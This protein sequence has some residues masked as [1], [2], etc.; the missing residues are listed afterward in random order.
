MQCPLSVNSLS[1][2]NNIVSKIYEITVKE[3]L[4]LN[5]IIF[6]TKN[7]DIPVDSVFQLA[8]K[9]SLTQY[10]NVD[11]NTGTILLQKPLDRERLV[12]LRIC[13]QID[14]CTLVLILINEKNQK[15]YHIEIHIED[16]NDNDPQFTA[17]FL[18]L[19]IPENVPIGYR[20][21]LERAKDLDIGKNA[22]I[23][24][25]LIDETFGE[26]SSERRTFK[27]VDDQVLAIEV[28][29]SLDFESKSKYSLKLIANDNGSPPRSTELPISINI[30]DVN[31]NSPKCIRQK[32]SVSVSEN[33]PIYSVLAKV[34]ATDIDSGRN[35]EL[36]YQLLPIEPESKDMFDIDRDTGTIT[37]KVAMDYEKVRKYNLDVVVSD[38]G[39]V[40]LSTICAVEI[41]VTD[42]ND[43]DP[44]IEVNILPKYRDYLI[45]SSNLIEEVNN[46]YFVR[47]REDLPAKTVIGQV[48]LHDRDNTDRSSKMPISFSC[49][50]T[51]K[52]PF[53]LSGI[54]NFTYF[55]YSQELDREQ[56]E[57]YR[58]LL[59]VNDSG[60]PIRSSSVIFYLTVD[61]VNDN[62][63]V[64]NVT[65]SKRLSVRENSAIG[66]LISIINATDA[67][68]ADTNNSRIRFL[69]QSN[70]FR[71]DEITGH[72][73]S[74]VV[75]D[76]EQQSQYQIEI[77]AIDQNV[78]D[79][80]NASL[81]LIIDI[82]DEND[83]PPKF[84]FK[85]YNFSVN[86]NIKIGST[87]GRV[88]ATDD[89]MGS[90]AMLVYR[91]CNQTKPDFPFELLPD[92]I[93]RTSN[94]IDYEK[95][96]IYETEICVDD[97]GG[98]SATTKIQL[99]DSTKIMF[100]I[101][102]L[103]DN[104]PKIQLPTG[105]VMFL[106][107]DVTRNWNITALISDA[108]GLIDKITVT[109][110]HPSMVARHR[111]NDTYL[112]YFPFIVPTVGQYIVTV[113]AIDEM[114]CNV[115]CSF[116][117][118]VGDNSTEDVSS[119][120]ARAELDLIRFEM[121]KTKLIDK[122]QSHRRYDSS[123]VNRKESISSIT[124]IL[125]TLFVILIIL[126][127]LL[128]TIIS[129]K[130]KKIQWSTTTG[131]SFKSDSFDLDGD[132]AMSSKSNQEQ[133]HKQSTTSRSSNDLPANNKRQSSSDTMHVNIRR[134]HFPR[135][136]PILSGIS[137][138]FG[139]KFMFKSISDQSV[140]DKAYSN[141]E[142]MYLYDKRP[143]ISMD[144]RFSALMQGYRD[145]TDTNQRVSPRRWTSM[146]SETD[147]I[148]I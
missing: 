52:N 132:S 115:T 138:N 97:G 78:D 34:K 93:I 133:L 106:N 9:D 14:N 73:Y 95:Q 122:R 41:H 12:D 79:P 19:T 54:D 18:N 85:S 43:N 17:N 51:N 22:I 32:T 21:Y 144:N 57:Y 92:G 89:D 58:C 5:S 20:Y 24:Y 136:S 66:T 148:K 42:V 83:N 107:R 59:S 102:N 110:S 11:E 6:S 80:K 36:E 131:D 123:S 26:S 142:A 84:R 130:R 31:D 38:K 72:L 113:I 98:G 7:E 135:S 139:D 60:Y 29:K 146:L 35:G 40:S 99:T 116:V 101:K 90:N 121:E 118:V 39:R 63:P 143:W 141:A 30:E 124:I 96:P 114:L 69:C 117:I 47:L 64:F 77:V 16:I 109:V 87:V 61:D 119:L 67:D 129:H 76:R 137:Y 10:F 105:K 147:E 25:H 53:M 55:I 48:H 108:D 94:L 46:E 44:E 8:A 120:L 103:N 70:M 65:T 128:L 140:S 37:L 28:R 112:L 13:P 45:E 91:F 4:D 145:P 104:C 1:A 27:L 62:S 3:D 126:T 23:T 33:T 49:N 82:I 75:F 68:K 111:F 15:L 71:I 2:T 88:Q 127:A 81:K 100:L 56:V 134:Q 125:S 50:E 74:K 86:E